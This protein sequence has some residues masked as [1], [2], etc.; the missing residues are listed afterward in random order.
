MNLFTIGYATKPIV[1]FIEQL[2]RYGITAVADVR[3]VPYSAA[4]FDY[5]Q[6]KLEGH[7]TRAGIRYVYLGNELGPRSKDEAHYDSCGQVQFDRLIASTLF[8]QGVNRL[9]AGLQKGFNI[10][11]MCAEKD[12]ACCH[13]SLLIAYDLERNTA[14][15]VNH[16]THDGDLETQAQ[17]EA[18]LTDLHGVSE[19]LF[20]GAEEKLEEAYLRQCKQ[21]AY[22]KP[23]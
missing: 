10:A 2:Q 18:R 11:L 8:Q 1:T 7:L 12:P 15:Q 5:H 19:D 23:A 3:S 17:L 13:R 20:M 22:I 14:L 4:F 21:K 16:I 6:D 9:Q